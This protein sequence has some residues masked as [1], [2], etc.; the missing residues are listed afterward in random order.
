MQRDVYHYFQ[1]ACRRKLEPHFEPQAFVK[2]DDAIAGFAIRLSD[3]GAIEEVQYRCTTCMTL[4]A[5]CEHAAEQIRGAKPDRAR[6]L[7]AS[8]IL[9]SHPEIPV[10]RRSR[11]ILATSA[12]QAALDTLPI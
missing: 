12:V 3:H 9:G 5:L 2:D 7:T 1:Q 11:A 10:S 4:I 8:G 6:E